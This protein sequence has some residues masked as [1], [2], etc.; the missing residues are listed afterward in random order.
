[1]SALSFASAYRQLGPAEKVFVDAYVSDVERTAQRANERISLALYRVIGAD[2][3]EASRGLIE[4]P[5]VRAAITER[6]N[7]IAS[8]NE[9]TPH[10]VVKE[11][12]AIAFSS[13]GDY[14]D[15]GEDGLPGGPTFDLT[16]CTP[17]QLSAIKSFEIEETGGGLQ[18]PSRRKIKIILHDKIAGLDA[19]AKLMALQTP[20]NPYWR[21]ETARPMG[22]TALPS[23]T[24]ADGAADRYAA[25]ING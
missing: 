18:R 1:M 15:I 24:T 12:M 4:R 2:V 25:L 14:M 10:R 19:L 5:L 11:W 7:D 13:L 9:L 20:D 8:A 17:E 6:I 21:Q 23:D 16:K 22:H 3:V